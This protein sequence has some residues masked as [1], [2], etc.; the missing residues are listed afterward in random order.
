MN[1]IGQ[2]KPLDEQIKVLKQILLKNKKLKQVLELLQN[3]TLKDY[4]IGAGAINQTVLNYYHGFDLNYGIKD[5]DIVYYDEDSS[6]E[7]EDKIIN[8]VKAL[9]KNVDVE[10]DI[11]NE[12]R[13][14]LWYRDKF[15]YEIEQY[16]NTEEA[17]SK[18][19]ATITCVGVRLENNEIVVFAPYGLNDIFNMI[20]RPIKEEFEE[21][22]YILRAEKWAEK[23]PKLKVIKWDD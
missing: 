18:W 11:K 9:I 5:F 13:V 20:V 6:Y 14:H 10:V 7:K 2:N 23:W 15:G 17:I 1:L 4:Y 19:G 3:S 12:A 8:E 22:N 16:K 21:E